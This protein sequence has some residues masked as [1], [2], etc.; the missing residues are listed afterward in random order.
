MLSVNPRSGKIRRYRISE[1]FIQNA[2]G[3]AVKQAGIAKHATVRTLR[4]SF[5]AY[6][7][8]K[9]VNIRS[10]QELIGHKN[11]EIAIIYPHI[12]RAYRVH[13]KVHSTIST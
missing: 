10:M 1:K 9:K 6:I 2:V 11:V 4:R 5:A 7:L 13:P 8:M 3:K 12:L